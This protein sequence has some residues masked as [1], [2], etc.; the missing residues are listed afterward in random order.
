MSQN[1]TKFVLLCKK[2][3]IRIR[4]FAP[5]FLKVEKVDFSKVALN[6]NQLFRKK[7]LIFTSAPSFQITP[8]TR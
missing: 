1:K 5:L 2:F 3:K 4:S 8:Q 6:E 7:K